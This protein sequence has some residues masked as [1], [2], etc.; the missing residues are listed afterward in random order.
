MLLCAAST[1]L[2]YLV[3][4]PDLILCCQRICY[5][6]R[7]PGWFT[8]VPNRVIAASCDLRWRR[9]TFHTQQGA[10]RDTLFTS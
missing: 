10:T 3:A 1:G 9:Y 6:F 5:M 2:W 4:A 7:H 8:V